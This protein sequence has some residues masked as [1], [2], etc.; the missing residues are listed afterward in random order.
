[1]GI[2]ADRLA[3]A[4]ANQIKTPLK[5]TGEQDISIGNTL[6]RAAKNFPAS[7]AGLAFDTLKAFTIDLP[8]TVKSIDG[9]AQGIVNKFDPTT[10]KNE[11][12]V[13]G[14]INFYKHRYGSFAK[15]KEA[16]ATDPASIM[17]DAATLLGGFSG[18]LKSASLVSDVSGGVNTAKI[19]A[20]TGS[21]A[22]KLARTIDPI[23]ISLK[24][25]QSAL[26][27]I[28]ERLPE[29]MWESAVKPSTRL[30]L[31]DRKLIVKT[32]LENGVKPTQSGID[33]V[34]KKIFDINSAITEKINNAVA[35][36]GKININDLFVYIKPLR[37]DAT[38]SSQKAVNAIDNAMAD[39]IKAND[40]IG[41]ESLTPAQAQKLKIAVYN[42]A[43][44]AYADTKVPMF[45]KAKRA[46]GRAVKEQIENLHPE[47]KG[48]NKKEADFI[49]LEKEITNATKRLNN[50]EFTIGSLIP[51][52]VVG[53]AGGAIGGTT[54]ATIGS[55]VGLALTVLRQP[56]VR[57]ATAQAIHSARNAKIPS[58]ATGIRSIAKPIQDTN[59][60][61]IEP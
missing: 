50:R 39:I 26:K 60:L 22:G 61:N 5:N 46:I 45:K 11:E 43:Y 59:K 10:D 34:R 56:K 35:N 48:L 28:P 40:S 44:S 19:L 55:G 16:F 3:S 9:L 23:N 14:I 31:E 6:A 25:A 36:G 52:T 41:R 57:L 4:K 42:E 38:I 54:G 15:A 8:K 20:K 18:I 17:M 53:A 21:I 13:D 58:A 12:Y 32:A 47:I 7:A 37:D 51:A 27:A 30:S 49:K 2:Y 29:K 33:K 1:M 24:P